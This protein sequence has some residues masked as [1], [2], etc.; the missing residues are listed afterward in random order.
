[1]VTT[2]EGSL[3]PATNMPLNMPHKTPTPSPITT[4][5]GTPAPTFDYTEAYTVV[6]AQA[7]ISKNDW[8]VIAYVENLFD[9]SSITY[10]HPEGFL[11]SRYARV[12]PQTIGV[13]FSYE[14]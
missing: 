10:V 12:R 1:M 8:K 14:Y 3:S 5:S 2:I 13:R 11:D 4:S 7:G 9:D 6:N